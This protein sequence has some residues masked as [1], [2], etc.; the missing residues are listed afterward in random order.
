MTLFI[1]SIYNHFS[2]KNPHI[3][4]KTYCG[5]TIHH[6][7][8]L[9]IVKKNRQ[10]IVTYNLNMNVKQTYTVCMTIIREKYFYYLPELTLTTDH[11]HHSSYARS[12]QTLSLVEA[13]WHLVQIHHAGTG[14]SSEACR[15]NRTAMSYT[16]TPFKHLYTFRV[17]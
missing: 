11:H 2:L 17:R 1:C 16:F 6:T 14:H 4:F 8:C 3:F 10:V 15:E 13:Q 5:M 12:S 7:I 9:I